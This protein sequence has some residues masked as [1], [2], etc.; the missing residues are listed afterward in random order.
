MPVV[1]RNRLQPPLKQVPQQLVAQASKLGIEPIRFPKCTRQSAC[2]GGDRHEMHV[3]GYQAIGP[4]RNPMARQLLRHQIQIDFAVTFLKKDVLPLVSAL[5]DMVQ[6]GE[7]G[8]SGPS[9][10]ATVLTGSAHRPFLHQKTFL[11]CDENA[12]FSCSKLYRL[13]QGLS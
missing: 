3:V 8:N 4:A 2:L 10:H 1:H 5:S 7:N 11:E 13:N 6:A 9:C 12:T